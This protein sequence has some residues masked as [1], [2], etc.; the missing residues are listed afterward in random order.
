MDSY[1]WET[2]NKVTTPG[3]WGKWSNWS[4]K[5]WQDLGV[6]KRSRMRTVTRTWQERDVNQTCFRTPEGLPPYWLSEWVYGSWVNKSDSWPEFERQSK[7][8]DPPA[9]LPAWRAAVG[10]NV[11]RGEVMQFETDWLGLMPG[12]QSHSANFDG[13]PYQH[14]ER[15]RTELLSPGHH[16]LALS[17]GM[18][19]GSTNSFELSFSLVH[20]MDIRFIE[21]IL[22]LPVGAGGPNGATFTLRI[23]N[24]TS[25]PLNAVVEVISVAHGWKAVLLQPHVLTIEVGEPQEFTLQVELM[26]E[27][28]IMDDGLAAFTI[29]VAGAAQFAPQRQWVVRDPAFATAYVRT[30]LD[31]QDVQRIV[32]ANRGMMLSSTPRTF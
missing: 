1:S 26:N 22:D 14:N 10:P 16:V 27:T 23:G 3:P 18:E 9:E 24:N 7:W 29:A 32:S 12:V 31:P 8:F 13:E 25:D 2:R 6:S 20:K 5:T 19:D 21:P 15:I 30:S 11:V 17:V 4:A 28:G